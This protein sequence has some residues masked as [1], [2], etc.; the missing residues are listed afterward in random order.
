VEKEEYLAL[1][2][3]SLAHLLSH[4]FI[5][6]IPVVIAFLKLSYAEG[7]LLSG[8]LFVTYGLTTLPSGVI[9]D[10]IGERLVLIIYFSL[11]GIGS[12]LMLFISSFTAL[13]FIAGVIGL[14]GGLYHPVGLSLISKVF[15]DKRGRA[16]GIHGVAG[17]VGLTI[18]Q[19]VAVLAAATIKWTFILLPFGIFAFI[20]G[21]I[22]TFRK[23][24][25]AN[26]YPLNPVE[27]THL[28]VKTSRKTL[29]TKY[30]LLVLL[31]AACNGII[32]DGIK[33]FMHTYLVYARSFSEVNAGFITGVLIFS[34]GIVSQV[35]FGHLV[36]TSGTYRALLWSFG[37]LFFT[38]LLVPIL[39]GVLFLMLL[40]FL[41]FAIVSAQPGLNTIVAEASTEETRGLAYGLNFFM[42]YGIGGIA[43]PF[44]G[45]VADRY[46]SDYIFYI[47]TV[48]ALIGLLILLFVLPRTT[49]TPKV[50]EQSA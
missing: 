29:L 17:N 42:T 37:F 38:V 46:T 34:V 30:F 43:S 5:L 8:V 6:A 1:L 49:S 2:G 13:L 24:W 23:S 4:A 28:V 45:L 47:L 20:G 9:S 25:F 44:V 18:A 50:K 10:K 48:F 7:G 27:E 11:S 22:F 32:F 3:T 36:D 14:A 21:L 40:P 19:P 39:S 12:V 35:V 33:A 26:D 31:L 41:G 16:M 15:K